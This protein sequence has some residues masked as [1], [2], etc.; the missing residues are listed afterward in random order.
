[1][2]PGRR[3]VEDE[4]GCRVCGA[5]AD[6]CD[7]A[8]TWDRS[9]GA[10]GFKNTDLIVPL[11]AVIKGGPGCHD[12]YDAHELDL[13]PYLT[14]DEQVALVRAAG[15]IARA[16]RRSTPLS[17]QSPSQTSLRGKVEQGQGR[18]RRA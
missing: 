2:N 13:L 8:H 9:L 4:G 15:S 12:L 14:I 18:S 6:Q 10:R 3:K 1:M 11:C 17:A 7:A 5:P 16:Y